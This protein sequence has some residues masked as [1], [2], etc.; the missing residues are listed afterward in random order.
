MQTNFAFIDTNIDRS[1]LDHGK[2]EM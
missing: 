2:R 1:D